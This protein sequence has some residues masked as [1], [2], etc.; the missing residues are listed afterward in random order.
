[1]E[2]NFKKLSNG[3]NVYL[4]HPIFEDV[5]SAEDLNKLDEAGKPVFGHFSHVKDEKQKDKLNA[6][7][8]EA[9]KAYRA[10]E[11]KDEAKEDETPG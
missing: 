4:S 2:H 7:L 6:E 1:M 8:F 10:E 5:K 9:L 3:Q 11:E